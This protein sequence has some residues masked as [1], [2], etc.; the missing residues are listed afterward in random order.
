MTEQNFSKEL[1]D[2]VHTHPSLVKARP[3][4]KGLYILKYTQKTFYKGI[5]NRFLEE[6]RGTVVDE[7]FNVVTRPFTK[8]YNYGID[9][10][11]PVFDDN[12]I[13]TAIRKINGF[14][15]NV[16]FYQGDLLVTTSGSADGPHVDMAK[17]YLDGVKDNLFDLFY[18]TALEHYTL[19]F[20]CVHENDPHVIEEESGLYLIG[21]RENKWD[22]R[23]VYDH[24]LID[25]TAYFL[26]VKRPCYYRDITIGSL[27]QYTKNANHEGY[28]FYTKDGQS[29]KTKSPYYLSKKLLTRM[30]TTDKLL[31]PETEYF[32]DEEYYPLLN[33]VRS[34]ANEFIEMSEKDRIE[35][36]NDFFYRCPESIEEAELILEN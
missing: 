20:E 13:V 1:M 23:V 10:E 24:C 2:Y 34:M 3:V 14:L 17:E 22:S 35:V 11:S 36:I 12:E 32:I 33:Y 6:C 21:I 29:S 8:I 16:S 15:V 27:I 28:V 26:N 9:K 31:S 4:E 19:M 18:N 5:W 7:D 25:M 30:K